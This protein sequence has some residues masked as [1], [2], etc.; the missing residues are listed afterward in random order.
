MRAL[1]GYPTWF[2]LMAAGVK[3]IENRPQRLIR[4]EDY[5]KTFAWHH[6]APQP[7]RRIEAILGAIREVA[8]EL[9]TGIRAS[10]PETW[11]PWYR[12]AT[13]CGAITATTSI[14]RCVIRDGR[15]VYDFHSG[16]K[17]ELGD[18]D[19]WLSGRFGYVISPPVL[20]RE[21]VRCGGYQGFW[22]LGDDLERQVR[23]AMP[24]G[25]R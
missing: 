5:G 6:G 20:L 23:A 24:E 13:T 11:P 9:F 16:E 25:P 12:L 3:L 15:E 7:R 17:I 18:Q 8:P 19:R 4:H 2:G 1:T 10:D 21:P 14:E 22:T